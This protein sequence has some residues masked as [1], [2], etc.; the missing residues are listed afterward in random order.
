MQWGDVLQLIFSSE[1]VNSQVLRY[2]KFHITCGLAKRPMASGVWMRLV[3]NS[4]SDAFRQAGLQSG[5]MLRLYPYPCEQFHSPIFSPN[6]RTMACAGWPL[7]ALASF[8]LVLPCSSPRR[9][10]AHFPPQAAST[11]P[12]RHTPPPHPFP[13][14]PSTLGAFLLTVCAFRR[15]PSLVTH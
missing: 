5:P 8:F 3:P 14:C 7:F 15:H 13:S 12:F 2:A 6:F 10:F 4:R 1:F 11:R 9:G